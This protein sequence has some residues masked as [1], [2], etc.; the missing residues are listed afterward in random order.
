MN[1]IMLGSAVQT[2]LGTYLSLKRNQMEQDK[3]DRESKNFDDQQSYQQKQIDLHDKYFSTPSDQAQSDPSV[4]GAASANAALSTPN[5]TPGV[6]PTAA[7]LPSTSPPG[8]PMQGVVPHP[9][10]PAPTAAPAAGLSPQGTQASQ[11]IQDAGDTAAKEPQMAGLNKNLAYYS[12]MSSLA[13]AH[14]DINGGTKLAEMNE[15]LKKEGVSTALQYAQNAHDPQQII[16]AFNHVKGT[17]TPF[18]G[19]ID[20]SSI[21]QVPVMGADGKPAGTTWEFSMTHPNGQTETINVGDAANSLMTI[22]QNAEMHVRNSE[23]ALHTGEAADKHTLAGAQANELNAQAEWMKRRQDSSAARMA[24]AQN[25]PIGSSEDGKPVYM[26]NGQQVT[27]DAVGDQLAPYGGKVAGMAKAETFKHNSDGTDSS[28]NGDVRENVPPVAAK[29]GFLGMG[30]RPAV[31]GSTRITHA[32]GTVSTGPAPGGLA[33][34]G[35]AVPASSAPPKANW[36]AVNTKANPH[37]NQ[38]QL[39]AIYKQKFGG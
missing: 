12:E 14:G 16:A 34:Q 27:Y 2:G 10:A 19:D 39:E 31:P 23:L 26:I 15:T 3:S 11:S 6:A 25:K 37:M 36:M 7:P 24:I 5:A 20:P 33:P 17:G 18:D 22:Q 38:A 8:M 29:S 32:D 28:S 13:L 4:T 9:S 35:A 30:A 21:K 1:G